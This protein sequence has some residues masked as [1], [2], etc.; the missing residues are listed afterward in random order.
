LAKHNLTLKQRFR[1]DSGSNH[2]Q[3]LDKHPH[4]LVDLH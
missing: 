1:T 2:S 3:H 4:W